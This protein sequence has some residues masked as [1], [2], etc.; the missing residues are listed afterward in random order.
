MSTK[1]HLR[2][3]DAATLKLWLEQGGVL[4]IDVRSWSEYQ[5]GHL[6]NAQLIPHDTLQPSDLPGDGRVCVLYCRSG[7]RSAQAGQRLLNSGLTDEVIHLRGGILAW[8]AAGYD[9]TR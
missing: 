3:I 5:D 9:I 1:S 2:E 6:A 8:K 4:L 7:N